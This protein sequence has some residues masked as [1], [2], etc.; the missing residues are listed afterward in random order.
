MTD[1]CKLKCFKGTPFTRAIT[2]CGEEID[3]KDI[4]VGPIYIDWTRVRCDKCLKRYKGPR[5]KN[6]RPR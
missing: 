3:L 1:G 2:E 6:G 5:G 4:N